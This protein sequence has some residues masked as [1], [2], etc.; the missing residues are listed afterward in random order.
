MMSEGYRAVCP[1]CNTEIRGPHGGVFRQFSKAVMNLKIHWRISCD[2]PRQM[3]KRE[4]DVVA[5][6]SVKAI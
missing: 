1:F 6:G 2:A 4:K 3:N 5:T